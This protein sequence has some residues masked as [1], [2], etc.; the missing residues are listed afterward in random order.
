MW[1]RRVGVGVLS[2]FVLAGLFGLLG[3][4]TGTSHASAPGIEVEVRHP[5]VARPGLAVAWR[6]QVHSDDGF[7]E[8]IVV[9]QR[10]SYHEAFDFNGMEPAPDASTADGEWIEWE[11]DAPASTDF[12]VTIDSRVEPGVQ[13]P[14]EAETEVEAE[15]EHVTLDYETWVVP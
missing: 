5:V 7:D 4:R 8:P 6:L 2:L 3:V 15:G 14:L 1:F 13:L 9:R 10:R 12:V 11:W